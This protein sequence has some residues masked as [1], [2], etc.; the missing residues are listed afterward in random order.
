[1]SRYRTLFTTFEIRAQDVLLRLPNR[2]L[3]IGRHVQE[4]LVGLDSKWGEHLTRWVLQN[5][6]RTDAALPPFPSAGAV[7]GRKSSGVRERP[8]GKGSKGPG[9][10]ADRAKKNSQITGG[11]NVTSLGRSGI[12]LTQP[13]AAS[14]TLGATASMSIGAEG[15][16]QATRDRPGRP[17]ASG[18]GAR[19][20]STGRGGAT[21][22]GR[23]PRIG[24]IEPPPPPGQRKGNCGE[25]KPN[26]EG[27]GSERRGATPGSA[28]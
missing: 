8:S 6:L 22:Q 20:N 25:T 10:T 15:G 1:M 21:S 24:G 4:Y 28:G 19:A 27:I 23:L 18:R 14:A 9:D 2:R 7:T 11:T 3:H 17:R 26:R 12:P 16:T 5:A 13:G